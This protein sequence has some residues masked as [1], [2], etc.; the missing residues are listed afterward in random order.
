MVLLEVDQEL[1][2]IQVYLKVFS[3]EALKTLFFKRCDAD[4]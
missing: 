1:Y 4:R 2:K 3:E